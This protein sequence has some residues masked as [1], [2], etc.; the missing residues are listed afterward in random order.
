MQGSALK[1]KLKDYLQLKPGIVREK[2]NIPNPGPEPQITTDFNHS[3][4][5]HQNPVFLSMRNHLNPQ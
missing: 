5:K 4:G 1:Q 2:K 3:Q